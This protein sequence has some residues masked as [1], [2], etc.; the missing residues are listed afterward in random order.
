M[1]YIYCVN[2]IY[3][4]SQM[5][6]WH[7]SCAIIMKFKIEIVGTG[8]PD[9]PKTLNLAEHFR[10]PKRLPYDEVDKNMKRLP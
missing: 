4:L 6:W 2:A 3:L 7:T 1:R 9:C 10:E 8:V 5:L